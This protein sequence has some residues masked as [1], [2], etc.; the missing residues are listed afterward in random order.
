MLSKDAQRIKTGLRKVAKVSNI[1]KI[2]FFVLFAIYCLVALIVLVNFIPSFVSMASDPNYLP[3]A[4]FRLVATAI[5]LFTEAFVFYSIARLFDDM[6]KGNSP[7]TST[8]ARRLQIIG[9]L[10][11]FGVIFD[12]LL[13]IIPLPHAEMGD[14]SMGI[15][16]SASTNSG[17]KIDLSSMLWSMVFFV[18]SY[19]FRYGASLQQLSDDTV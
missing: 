15:V 2:I 19:I 9:F 7:F 13:P 16:S 5:S 17:M 12:N 8:Q 18:F 10:L 11:L 14:L 1:V 3:F 4:L 6:S